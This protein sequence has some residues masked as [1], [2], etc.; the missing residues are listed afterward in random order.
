MLGLIEVYIQE[1]TRRLPEKKRRD[2]ALELRST[3]EEMLPDDYSE[4]DVEEVLGELG[5]PATVASGYRA[6]PMH[7]IGPRYYDLYISLLKVVFPIAA[8]IA[9][10]SLIIDSFM[11]FSQDEAVIPKVIT[12]IVEGIL[13]VLE[14]GFQVFFWV[15]I[16]FAVLERTDKGKDQSPLSASLQKWTPNDLRSIPYIHKKKEITRFNVFSGLMWTAIWTTV[17]FYANQF[18]GV[19]EG[20]DRIELV[21]PVFQQDILLN[22]WPFILLVIAMEIW[23]AFYKSIKRQWTKKL[24]NFN[25]VLEMIT[26]IGFIVIVSNPDVMNP[27][28]LTYMGSLSDTTAMQFRNAIVGG[29]ITI[30]ILAAA[31]NVFDGYRKSRIH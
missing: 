8:G 13:R 3:I 23:L 4:L 30:F 27:E 29:S 2:I 31:L 22:Y 11:G 9:L 15:T 10:I 24:A 19:Y 20:G 7:L 1:V 18:V 5:N 26:T 12:L 25:L 21:I 16:V 6:Q 14:V 17:Y 28:F